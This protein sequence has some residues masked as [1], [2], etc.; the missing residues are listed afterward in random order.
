MKKLPSVKNISK[1]PKMKSPR[2][3]DINSEICKVFS[4]YCTYS[5]QELLSGLKICKS[6]DKLMIAVNLSLEFGFSLYDACYNLKKYR[7]ESIEYIEKYDYEKLV[8]NLKLLSKSIKIVRDEN[9]PENRKY[10]C[11]LANDL[12]DH[13][14]RDIKEIFGEQEENHKG[15]IE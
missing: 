3:K 13:M 1:A 8:D 7:E 15:H 9:N 6:Y 12:I 10:A 4:K 2:K 5:Q 14:F 11:G